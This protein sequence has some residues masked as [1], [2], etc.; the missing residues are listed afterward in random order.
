MPA[1]SWSGIRDASKFGNESLQT[2]PLTREI[3]GSEDCLYLNVYT[4]AIQPG[5]KRAVMV[6][7][8]GGSFLLGSGND[9]VYGPDHIVRKDVVLVTLNYRLGVFGT[10]S[11]IPFR[12]TAHANVFVS[13]TVN[14][15]LRTNAI[16]RSTFMF[17]HINQFYEITRDV[18]EV[19]SPGFLNLDHEVAAGNQALKDALLALQW[20]NEN[21]SNFGGDPG[22]VTIFGESAGGTIVHYLAT[23]PLANGTNRQLIDTHVHVS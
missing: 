21:I 23:C 10:S 15:L 11:T 19:I 12:N 16:A 20:V 1:E 8:H 17:F 5:T 2:D 4:T 22:N 7:I 3:I 6:W 9:S 14:F 18:S 13:F